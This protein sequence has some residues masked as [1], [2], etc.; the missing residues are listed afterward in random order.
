MAHS[1][2]GEAPGSRLPWSDNLYTETPQP[3]CLNDTLLT[4]AE[5]PQLPG[6]GTSRGLS[7]LTAAIQP[8]GLHFRGGRAFRVTSFGDGYGTLAAAHYGVTVNGCIMSLSSCSTM[9][10][11]WT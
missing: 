3:F 6:I 1:P 5:K 10:Q 8:H 4:T 2:N 9:W 11:W 7:Q